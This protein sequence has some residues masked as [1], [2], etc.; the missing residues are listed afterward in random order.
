MLTVE[1]VVMLVP[2]GL[3][4]RA[5]FANV[6]TAQTLPSCC[7]TLTTV[8]LAS[9]RALDRTRSAPAGLASVRMV[10]IPPRPPPPLIAARAVTSVR[11]RQPASTEDASVLA[12]MMPALQPF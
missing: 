12:A 3:T 2:T 10:L 11:T 9:M 5:G 6:L 1:H 4:V 8:V 7:L